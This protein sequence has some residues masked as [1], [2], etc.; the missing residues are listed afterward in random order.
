MSILTMSRSA[1]LF[2][3]L[4]GS[5]AGMAICSTPLSIPFSCELGSCVLSGGMILLR[6]VPRTFT[7]DPCGLTDRGSVWPYK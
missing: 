7:W 1:Q 4:A 3:V 5:A 6:T 2:A